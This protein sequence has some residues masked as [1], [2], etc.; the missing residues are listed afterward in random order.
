LRK[1][2][3]LFDEFDA[4]VAEK[5][6]DLEDKADV[7]ED[8]LGSYLVKVSACDL[9][10]KDS[11]QVT[12]LL[13]IIGD[14]ERIS[15]HAVNIVESA[16]EI[17]EK[18]IEFSA[19]AQAEL[20]TLRRAVGDI[21][22]YAESA[23]INNDVEMAIEIEPLE[24]VVD[25]LR[26]QI[27]LNHIKRLQKSECTIEHG[28]ILS[29]MLNNF[30]RVSDHCSNIGCCVIEISTDDSLDLHKYLHQIKSDSEVYQRKYK[31]YSEEYAIK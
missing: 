19:D 4:K 22:G 12:K 24:Q 2:L 3:T 9:N 5:I 20:A 14:L 29:D 23:F 1:S 6:R 27:K 25:D 13:R 16:E 17:K 10:Q 7:Y 28:F 15:D 31:R 30:E 26:D 11:E 18:K 8:A 21:I